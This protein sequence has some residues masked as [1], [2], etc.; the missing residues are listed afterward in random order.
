MKQGCSCWKKHYSKLW[1]FSTTQACKFCVQLPW[2][3]DDITRVSGAGLFPGVKQGAKQRG[4]GIGIPD[5]RNTKV[6]VEHF[7][8]DSI[9]IALVIENMTA[10]AQEFVKGTKHKNRSLHLGRF[11]ELKLHP[12]YIGIN[13]G[14]QCQFENIDNWSWFFEKATHLKPAVFL[15]HSGDKHDKE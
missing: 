13:C 11:V 7:N 14:N 5:L 4:S 12:H 10:S 2:M 6:Q 15:S 3:E 8:S 9:L 1:D